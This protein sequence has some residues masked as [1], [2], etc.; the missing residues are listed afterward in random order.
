MDDCWLFPSNQTV[1]HLISLINTFNQKGEN[2]LLESAFVQTVWRENLHSLPWQRDEKQW[3]MRDSGYLLDLRRCRLIWLITPYRGPYFP[4]LSCHFLLSRLNYG[5]RVWRL[6][7][8]SLCPLCVRLHDN[9]VSLYLRLHIW[10]DLCK[11][12]YR[13]YSVTETSLPV[14]V[15]LSF[16]LTHYGHVWSAAVTKWLASMSF[17]SLIIC[18]HQNKYVYNNNTRQ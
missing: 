4:L 17:D 15:R 11:R 18:Y 14:L 13:T 5:N 7:H 9:Q 16:N 10:A 8:C 12:W 1:Q 6:T 3:F 2:Q